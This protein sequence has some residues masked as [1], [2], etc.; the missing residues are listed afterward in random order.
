MMQMNYTIKVDVRVIPASGSKAS[1]M[2]GLYL[3]YQKRNHTFKP[4]EYQGRTSF[5]ADRA[6]CGQCTLEMPAYNDRADVEFIVVPRN[7]YLIGFGFVVAASRQP[8]WQGEINNF[9]QEILT[10]AAR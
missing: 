5:G 9:V 4:S 2:L 10:H 3:D 6:V 8:K 1:E 7:H